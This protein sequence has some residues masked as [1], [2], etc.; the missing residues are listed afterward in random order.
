MQVFKF[1]G[2][3]VRD[4]ESIK[5]VATIL[6][7]ND[8]LD[9]VVVFSAMGKTTN[10]LEDVVNLYVKNDEKY[11]QYLHEIRD[12]HQMVSDDLFGV[13]SPIQYK[14][15]ALFDQVEMFCSQHNSDSYTFIYDQIVS[16]GELASSTL[17]SSYLNH[18]G[19]SNKW[20]DAR[21]LI[22]T[23]RSFTDAQVDWETT[24][25]LVED[26][27]KELKEKTIITQGFIAST[28]ERFT[29][30]LG[31]EGSDYTA[32]VL[33]YC[34]SAD[35]I[36]IWKDVEGIMNADP[37][38]F[39]DTILIPK[40]AFK[41]AI[42]MTYYGAKV[43]HSK[44]IR[45]LQNKNI[46]LEVRSFLR[47]VKGGTLIHRFDEEIQYP[48]IIVHKKEQV[49]LEFSAKDFSF[50]AENHMQ[51]IFG[52]FAKARLRM[53]IM[54]NGAINFLAGIDH[55]TAKIVEVIHSLQS[56]FSISKTE[57]LDL[58]TIRHYND[59]VLNRELNQKTIFLTQKTNE[60]IQVLCQS[61]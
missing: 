52:A 39:K 12:Y 49:L 29:T 22:R 21:D 46:P 50:I 61:S 19:I 28:S 58:I 13:K 6:E 48:P 53:N 56:S 3:S 55:N 14:I 17:V 25:T 31:R 34:L 20:V 8:E 44:T 23:D 36:V 33:S 11:L 51:E 2:A 38:M 41:E 26:K 27:I 40:I 37:K 10:A 47:S 59:E 16:V 9:K 43:I 5:N 18:V 32:A 30:T 54:Q 1:G 15:F 60:T 7:Q 42:E 4:A 35:K 57:N 45:P 24:K